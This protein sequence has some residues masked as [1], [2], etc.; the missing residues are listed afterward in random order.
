MKLSLRPV[1]SKQRLQGVPVL[2]RVD[3]NVPLKEGSFESSLKLSRS[4]PFVKQLSKRGAVVILLTHIGRPKKYDNQLSSK[5]L[6]KIMDK[7]GLDIQFHPE[8]VSKKS[9][10]MRLKLKL[11]KAKPG[12]VHLLENVR[13]EKGEEQNDRRLAQ[14]YA[15]LGDMFINDAFASSHRMHVSVVGIAKLLPSY[16]GPSL[17]EEVSKL[18][19]L[20]AKPPTPFIAIIG[21]K[22]LST[23][24]PVIKQLL[25]VCDKILVGGA[26]ATPFFVGQGKSVGV[27]YLERE[28]IKEAKRL[29]KNKEILLPSDV[30]VTDRLSVS[31]V[32]RRVDIGKIEK[33]DMIVDIGPKTM[34][35][36]AKLIDTAKTILWNGPVG[37]SECKPCG[38]G[39]RFIARVVAARSNGKAFGVAGGGDT[40]PIIEQTRTG[41]WLDFVS[42]GGG[43]MLE[44]IALKGKLPGINVLLK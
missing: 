27:S 22:K 14:A 24:I 26:M 12:S 25:S 43:A 40:L 10:R 4:I 37:L 3:W 39:S 7:Y 33:K 20:L 29:S 19:R 42:T 6:V 2:V 17:I 5:R 23:K 13:F 9:E 44:F 35:E 31:P 11:S 16:A 8:T 32:V 1:P 28:S 34:A 38:N 41:K 15:E 30:M 18:G 36:W 21:G